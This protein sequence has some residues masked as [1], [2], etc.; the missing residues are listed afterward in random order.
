[1][2]WDP[3][4]KLTPIQ[5]RPVYFF[6]RIIGDRDGCL[7]VERVE[8]VSG[9]ENRFFLQKAEWNENVWVEVPKSIVEYV[10]EFNAS[11]QMVKDMLDKGRTK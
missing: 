1:M 9:F 2:K 6:A 8:H 10:I 11:G 3:I 4:V 5:N 7:F